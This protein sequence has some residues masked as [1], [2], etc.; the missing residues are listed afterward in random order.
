MQALSPLHLHPDFQV[1]NLDL[2]NGDIHQNLL[3]YYDICCEATDLLVTTSCFSRWKSGKATNGSAKV[4]PA[5]P[6]ASFSKAHSNKGGSDNIG[7]VRVF[8]FDDNMN[9]SLGTAAGAAEAK[10]I[11]CLRDITSGEYVDFSAGCNG[12]QCESAFRH[13]LIHCSPKYHNVLVQ[14]N[15]LD[16][17]SN[18]DYFTSI[19]VKYRRPG[20]RL[21]VFM[22]V[23]GTI[24]W[25][26]TVMDQCPEKVLLGTML[27][28]VEVRPQRPFFVTWGEQP[29]LRLARPRSLKL[30]LQDLARGDNERFHEFWQRERCEEILA[31]LCLSADL[32]WVGQTG[33]FS[34]KEFFSAYQD[35][36][37]ELQKLEKEQ[38]P[39]S[40][41]ITSS[42]FHCFN[43]LRADK[44][45]RHAVIIN[46]FG[47]DTQHVVVRSVID[48]RRVHHVAI[49]FEL[50]SER[51][52]SRFKQQFDAEALPP[53]APALPVDLAGGTS[54]TS[55]DTLSY[56]EVSN[57][58]S[59]AF[60]VRKPS[61]G[62]SLGAQ[63][64]P[65][66]HSLE[67][68]QICSERAIQEA[69]QLNRT[70]A[71]PAETLCAGDIIHAVNAV[72]GD[73]RSIRAASVACPLLTP[74]SKKRWL[75]PDE[76]EKEFARQTDC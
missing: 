19:L 75:S 61:P 27:G 40:K 9:L 25:N 58:T 38:G 23:N 69:N 1:S 53:H 74:S 59:F 6:S 72:Q 10:G 47:M 66:E 33:C 29:R 35:Y 43:S 70:S 62:I 17:M 32:G 57:Y 22:D 3:A 12:F 14:A 20:E 55:G 56:L 24:L 76:H 45:S 21:I 8:F 34:S 30:L 60:R 16:A 48:P 36:W 52:A 15:I 49:N 44:E 42:W 11:C 5:V 46:S 37:G 65:V 41:G 64:T 28:F 51:D 18:P 7:A 39:V 4:I 26:D 63:V 31:Q 13:T 68:A 2:Q 54:G 50:W 71:P 73:T 67:V